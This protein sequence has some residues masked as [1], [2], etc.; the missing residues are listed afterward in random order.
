MD[1]G[2]YHVILI[3]YK[4][5]NLDEDAV[6]MKERQMLAMELLLDQFQKHVSGNPGDDG[7]RDD[8]DVGD[9]GYV[10]D[11]SDEGDVDMWMEREKVMK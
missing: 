6:F 5:E 11:I 1:C 4:P 9:V 7:D 8:G 3:I 2:S 10:G